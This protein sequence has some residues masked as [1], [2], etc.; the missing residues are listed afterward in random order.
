MSVHAD[1]DDD[2]DDGCVTSLKIAIFFRPQNR[3]RVS[4]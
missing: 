2:D 1:D 4:L 3:T